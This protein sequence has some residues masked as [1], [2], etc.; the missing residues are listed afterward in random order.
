MAMSLNSYLSREHAHQANCAALDIVAVAIA[1]ALDA[2]RCDCLDAYHEALSELLRGMDDV[3]SD[4]VRCEL[5]RIDHY[6][7]ID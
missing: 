2:L 1:E 3:A 6:R 7:P 5:R 4:Y